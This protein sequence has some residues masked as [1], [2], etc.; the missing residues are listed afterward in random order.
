MKVL[1]GSGGFRTEERRERLVA[2]MREHFGDIRRILFV[3]YAVGDPDTV[4]EMMRSRSL[5]AGY[6]LDGIHRHPDPVAAVKEAEGIYMGGGNSFRLIDTLHREGLLEPIRERVLGDGLPYLGVSAGANV[7]C[8]TMMTTNDM[9]IVL[10]PS[11]DALGLVAFQINP[12]YYEGST[13]VRELPE[14][15][16]VEHF[17]E[18]RA[19]R[20]G[21]YHELIPTPVVGL[22]EGTMLSVRDE[23]MTLVGGSARLFRAGQDPAVIPPG[24]IAPEVLAARESS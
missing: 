12:H 21:E 4:L 10:P 17:G 15:D 16:L 20:I 23:R 1:L 8:P 3:P 2:A 13:F 9:P 14:A 19:Q 11:F 18:T 5:D 22:F 6:E 24:D 7:A